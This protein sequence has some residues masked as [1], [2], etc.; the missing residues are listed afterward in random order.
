MSTQQ[1]LP[2]T[3]KNS[4]QP[5]EPPLFRRSE[6]SRRPANLTFD[7]EESR[8]S[9][10]SGHPHLKIGRKT[11]STPAWI[12]CAGQNEVWSR[13]QVHYV[14]FKLAFPVHSALLICTKARRIFPHIFIC[15]EGT[16]GCAVIF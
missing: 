2:K 4:S 13:V 9:A 7:V 15:N 1:R 11:G 16:A 12:E 10:E 5:T 3:G 8:D 14:R 6:R